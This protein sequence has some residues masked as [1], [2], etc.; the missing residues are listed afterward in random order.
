VVSVLAVL[1]S[2]LFPAIQVARVETQKTSCSN[3]LHQLG[4]ATQTYQSVFN[5]LPPHNFGSAKR[6][7]TEAELAT[8]PSRF[9]FSAFVAL[10][11]YLNEE[12]LAKSIA[13]NEAIPSE[14]DSKY[15]TTQLKGH[16]TVIL[17]SL[18]C[19]AE[20]VGDRRLFYNTAAGSTNYLVSSGDIPFNWMRN[21]NSPYSDVG[22]GRGAFQMKQALN[23]EKITDGTS[24]TILFSE[25]CLG[26]RNSTVVKET[27]YALC[28]QA[29]KTEPDPTADG[30][31][32]LDF[33]VVYK[34]IASG[35][36]VRRSIAMGHPFNQSAAVNNQGGKLWHKSDPLSTSFSTIY[37]PNGPSCMSNFHYAMA[38]TSYHL[39]G[40]N[41][42]FVDG[43]VRLVSNHID[44]G[45]LSLPPVKKGNSPYGI[46]GILGSASGGET[47]ETI[48]LH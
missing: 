30:K 26:Q 48:L 20:R 1:V 36:Y 31:M 13:D 15:L 12:K 28:W 24:N 35:K 14:P 29:G 41:V 16:W 40:V 46:W 38:P 19:P 21:A 39:G 33:S 3:K 45:D 32:P 42:C 11:P 23:I 47:T 34:N 22:V 7:R 37:P 5:S 17:S 6:E 44:V 25:R 10:L 4:V 43:S 2:L 9:A 18:I 8:K 27:Y